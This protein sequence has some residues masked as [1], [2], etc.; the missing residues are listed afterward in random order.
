[1]NTDRETLFRDSS[2]PPRAVC[3]SHDSGPLSRP[4][5]ANPGYKHDQDHRAE[6]LDWDV[7]S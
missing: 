6:W 7:I 3:T 2:V 4:F 5:L 1:M